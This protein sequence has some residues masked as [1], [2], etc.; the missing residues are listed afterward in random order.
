MT[1]ALVS[2][3]AYGATQAFFSDTEKNIGNTFSSGTIDIA[4]DGQ[5]PW[6]RG[7]GYELK[8]MKPSQTDYIDFVVHNVGTNPVNLYK[9]LDSFLPGDGAQSEPECLAEGGA[10]S[11]TSC[12]GQ[13]NPKND[14]DTKIRYDMRVELYNHDPAT[15]GNPYWWETIY[16]DSDNARLSSILNQNMYLGMVPVGHY[17]KVAQSYHLDSD[18]GNEYQGDNLS[19]NITL[20]AEQLGKSSLVLENKYLADTDVSHHVWSPGG[21]SDGKDA[22][23]SYK[24]KERTFDYTL[25]VNGMPNGTYSLVAWEDPLL[26]W[27]WANRGVA[28]KL[29]DVS[30]VGSPT[31]LTGSIELNNTL[32]NTKVW[33][34]PGTYVNGNASTFPW[35]ALN[36]LFETGLMDYYDAD[37]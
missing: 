33:L 32:T 4:V 11:G 13:N 8:D 31:V 16:Q 37:L 18:T 29:A 20:N 2:G 27:N 22:V 19:F 24:I 15:G 1:I 9:T 26:T 21:I 28:I 36:T 30:I 12:T 23:L 10:W 6:T 35:D 5:N 17:L 3:G 14:I 34:I 7:A 25:T